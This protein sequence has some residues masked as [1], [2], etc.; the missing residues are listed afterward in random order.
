MSL[1]NAR[2]QLDRKCTMRARESPDAATLIRDTPTTHTFVDYFFLHVGFAV[3]RKYRNS[4][5]TT[6]YEVTRHIEGHDYC[7]ALNIGRLRA[8]HRC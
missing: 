6:I 2:D 5:D 3:R 8:F 1:I 4:K 7:T